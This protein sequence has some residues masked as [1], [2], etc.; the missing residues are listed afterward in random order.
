MKPMRN[1]S[2]AGA[3]TLNTAPISVLAASS[4]MDIQALARFM[5]APLRFGLFADRS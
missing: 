3:G 1:S 4:D 5:V 2:A